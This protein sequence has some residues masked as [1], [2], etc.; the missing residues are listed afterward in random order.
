MITPN[1][2][3]AN[4]SGSQI[5]DLYDQLNR[6]ADQLDS[7]NQ[8]LAFVA[9]GQLSL[10][11]DGSSNATVQKSFQHGLGYAPIF[12]LYYNLSTEPGIWRQCDDYRVNSSTG[13]ATLG[14][15][16]SSDSVNINVQVSSYTTM[17]ACTVLFNWFLLREP[18]QQTSW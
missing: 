4:E 6:Q 16:G 8:Q 14:F 15:S 12:L 5:T 1:P 7:F 11:Y 9:N 18:A 10:A 3:F 13:A 2:L 17:P